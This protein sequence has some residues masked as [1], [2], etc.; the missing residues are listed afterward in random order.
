MAEPLATISDLEVLA[1]DLSDDQLPPAASY[2]RMASNLLR[3]KVAN[4]DTR[5]AS[6]DLDPEMVADVVCAMVNRVLSNPQGV[7]QETVGSMSVTYA[8][9]TPVGQLAVTADELGQLLPTPTKRPPGS[10]RLVAPRHEH[11][12]GQRRFPSWY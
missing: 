11:R 7:V 10:I 3:S 1:G 2:L 9:G 8:Q 12:H 5:I 6:G 4:L